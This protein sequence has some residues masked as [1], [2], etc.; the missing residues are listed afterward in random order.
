MLHTFSAPL[1]LIIAWLGAATG[2]EAIWAPHP[3]ITRDIYIGTPEGDHIAK[4]FKES[5]PRDL[6]IP[7]SELSP[8]F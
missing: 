1:E 7:W 5:P 8:R 3:Q 4:G 2:V 6:G